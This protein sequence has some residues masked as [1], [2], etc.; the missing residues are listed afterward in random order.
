MKWGMLYLQCHAFYGSQF[1]NENTNSTRFIFKISP[2]IDGKQEASQYLFMKF[3]IGGICILQK[4]VNQYMR[5]VY[6][7]ER[8]ALSQYKI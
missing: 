3:E 6:K 7:N 2:K 4:S 5:Q 1:F 8:N